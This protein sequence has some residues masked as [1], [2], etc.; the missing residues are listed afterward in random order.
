MRF[1]GQGGQTP[2]LGNDQRFTAIELPAAQWL[3]E[4]IPILGRFYQEVISGHNLLV[5]L[6]FALVAA[7]SWVLFK[8]RFGLRIRATGE[9]PK[10]VDTAGIS[11]ASIRYRALLITGLMCG[12]AG[13]YLSIGQNASFV[14]EMTAGQGYIALA[15]VILGKWRPAGAMWGCLLFGALSAMETRLQSVELPLVGE[16]PTQL[17]SAL[18]YI[19]TVVLLAGFIGKSIAPKAVGKPYIK[20]R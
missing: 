19:I 5:Y 18:P 3:G 4:N 7:A 11:V 20:E 1:F 16:L 2:S 13:A 9:E 6:A 10:A 17:F 14:R 12:L 15:A 8:T